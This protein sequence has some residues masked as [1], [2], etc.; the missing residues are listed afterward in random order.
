MKFCHD[1]IRAVFLVL[2]LTACA[3]RTEAGDVVD[4]VLNG[5]EFTFDADTGCVLKM[6][7]PS[8]GTMLDTNV[9][10]ASAIDLAYPITA[11]EPLRLAARYST[12]A[13]IVKAADKVT[14][15]W[16]RLGTSR[17]VKADSAQPV[18][19]RLEYDK[20]SRQNRWVPYEKSPFDIEG[21]VSAQVTFEAAPDGRSVL[22]RCR[23]DNQSANPIP[24]VLF[25]DFLGLT[26]AAGEAETE[27][28]TCGFVSKPFQEFKVGED[29][30]GYYA[31]DPRIAG[32]EYASGGFFPTTAMV[33]KW[34]DLGSRKGG[35]SLFRKRW[36]WGPAGDEKN[37]Q[38]KVWLHLSELDDRLRLACTH[39]VDIKQGEQWESEEYVLTPHQH[40]WA[41]GIEP[42]RDFVRTHL[43]REFPLPKHV[44]DGLGF[45]TV[46]MTEAYPNDPDGDYTFKCADLPR[47]AQ[48]SKDHGLDEMCL[49]VWNLNLQVPVTPP[50]PQLGTQEDMA[51]AVKECK[52][53]GVNVNLFTSQMSVANPTAE[54]W[55][56]TVQPPGT[57]WTYH[58][59][60]VPVFRP[61]Y[62]FGL[63][64]AGLSPS[65][66][67]WQAELYASMQ[68][69]IDHISPSIGWDQFGSFPSDPGLY[70]LTEKIRRYATARDPNAT[71]NGEATSNIDNDALYVDYQWTW[72]STG[73]ARACTSVYPTPRL[74]YPLDRSSQ[75]VKKQ[76]MDN[77]YMNVFPSKPGGI[78]GSGLIADWP[79][80]SKALK[81]CAALRRQFLPYFVEGTLIGDC[82]LTEVPSAA[83]VTA[84]ALEDRLLMVSLPAS[85]AQVKYAYDL[86]PW[87][88]S[89]DSK[90]K[91]RIY[92]E[93]GK[94]LQEEVI[95]ENRGEVS[96]ASTSANALVLIEFVRQP[97]E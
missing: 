89:G 87:L 4:A 17:Q 61:P 13:R 31:T 65:D 30:I 83:Y 78:N 5:L 67:R 34:M 77:L 74:N 16:D 7:Y 88:K 11:F 49:W 43:N 66:E 57:S 48:E 94:V 27:F 22:M 71:F 58:T 24:Q 3:A 90:F 80:L 54:R 45:R 14:I 82:A 25:P 96:P 56:L 47:L 32:K 15:T 86:E 76:F 29:G 70:T 21:H 50:F 64:I 92:D 39:A 52:A 73:D 75:T 95:E 36:N 26:A 68:H 19:H 28:R 97:T 63:S 84:Y 69:L 9:A 38:E 18:A 62:A 42:Y 23:V 37:Y 2:V 53:I 81:Q 46:Y 59:E 20:E 8:V 72:G 85:D 44:R 12:N 55:G 91:M 35:L 60:F 40:G 93:D 79:K 1:A 6:S 10:R 33:G 41:K 51:A